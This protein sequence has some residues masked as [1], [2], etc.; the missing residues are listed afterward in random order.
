M[1][2]NIFLSNNYFVVYIMDSIQSLKCVNINTSSYREG[3]CQILFFYLIKDDK[4]N[5]K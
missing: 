2:E 1:F 3:K 4:F 5:R